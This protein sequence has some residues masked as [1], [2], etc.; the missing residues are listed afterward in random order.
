MCKHLFIFVEKICIFQKKIVLLHA[1]NDTDT[2]SMCKKISY[3]G[4][5]MIMLS[6]ASCQTKEL[7][8]EEKP[9][10]FQVEFVS[11]SFNSATICIH[12]NGNN[13][14]RYGGFLLSDAHPATKEDV[15]HYID[16]ISEKNKYFDYWNQ[17]KHVEAYYNLLPEKQYQLVL[18]TD[19]SNEPIVFPFETAKAQVLFEENPDWEV[20]W[21]GEALHHNARKTV[22]TN[23]VTEDAKKRSY[24]AGVISE[25]QYKAC[26]SV[27]NSIYWILGQAEKSME[28][29]EDWI[30]NGSVSNITMKTY[31]VLEPGTYYAFMI[32]ILPDG[33]PTGIYAM[34]KSIVDAYT[35]LLSYEIWI[36]NWQIADEYGNTCDVSITADKDQQCLMMYGWGGYDWPIKVECDMS[37]STLTYP[38]IYSQV[39]AHDVLFDW[40]SIAFV[41]DVHLCASY[42]TSQGIYYDFNSPR[43]YAYL[44]DGKKDGRMLSSL[45][46]YVVDRI[47]KEIELCYRVCN[48]ATGEWYTLPNSSFF[49]DITMIRDED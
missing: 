9:F 48:S 34:T 19:E 46:F 49:I 10:A 1:I 35:P 21:S 33:T 11:V 16:S 3:I 29:K 40:D 28:S 44:S 6:F 22:I 47:G 7:E 36:D 4:L 25:E 23:V 15:I 43:A 17:R 27:A 31:S 12:H 18:F 45:H 26:N 30:G 37:T 20:K 13:R 24:Y 39:V 5:L 8:I 14:N 2:P 41:S 38:N 32:G 42:L